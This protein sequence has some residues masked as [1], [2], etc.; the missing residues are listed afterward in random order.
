MAISPSGNTG[1]ENEDSL[2]IVEA[3]LSAAV[4]SLVI[5][6][7]ATL[8]NGLLLFIMYK[9]P[10]RYFRAHATS[11]LVFSLALSDLI[12]GL[13]SQLFYASYLFTAAAGRP[14]TQVLLDIALV[15][16]HLVTTLSIQTV[17]ALSIDRF[18]AIRL[19]VRYKDTVT[20]KKTL[21]CSVCIWLFTGLFEAIH[22]AVLPERVFHVIELHTQTTLPLTVLF[23]VYLATFVYF[24]RYSRSTVLVLAGE[25]PTRISRL[26]QRNIGLE[27]KMTFTIALIFVVL[28]ISH[29]PNLVV[30]KIQEQCH[31][32]E[33]EHHNCLRGNSSFEVF[34]MFAF[35]LLSVSCALNPFFYAF[36]I[37]QYNAAFKRLLRSVRQRRT[38]TDQS[39]VLQPLSGSALDSRSRQRDS[40]NRDLH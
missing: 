12:G 37:P 30:N 17:V 40:S 32:A 24:K 23:S 3:T 21:V 31:G 18:L 39:T 2:H 19:R 7:S 1:H 13:I 29:I 16:S 28:L 9:D 4:F 36:R 11:Y 25:R 22:A 27:K 26:T 14:N 8:S 34:R 33:A 20:V 5:G 38:G 10:Y 15:S 35:P 6:V